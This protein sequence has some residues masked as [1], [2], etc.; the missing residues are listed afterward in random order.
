MYQSLLIHFHPSCLHLKVLLGKLDTLLNVA[1]EVLEADVEELLLVVGDLADGV[2]LLNTVGAKLDLRGEKVNTLV[3]VQGRVDVS[4]LNDTL[5][6]LGGLEERL[7]ETGTGH[8]HGQSSRASTALGLD[9]L[10]TTELDALDVL[11]ELSALE[12]VA[13]LREE[14]H[15]GGTRVAT[16]DNNV[17]R[18]G[19]GALELRD[20]ARGTDNVKSGDTEESLGVVDALGL[21]D[22]CGDGDG[23][24]DGVGDDE[25]VGVG[26]VLGA[27]LGQVADNRGVG[28]EEVCS[29]IRVCS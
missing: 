24:V 1:L 23:R 20:E 18:G 9:D 15:N 12:V 6:A 3:L 22:L 26:A 27:G 4:G 14:G 8:G 16:D 28:V 13:R 21:E 11:V 10:V 29:R 25:E 2:D 7:G 5:L 19:V 17:L